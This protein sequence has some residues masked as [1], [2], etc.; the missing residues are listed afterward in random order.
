MCPPSDVKFLR[1]RVHRD[2]SKSQGAFVAIV[3][4]FPTFVI[5]SVH[6]AEKTNWRLFNKQCKAER[7]HPAHRNSVCKN[8]LH[9]GH[10]TSVCM[11]NSKIT[12]CAYCGG[13]H[14]YADHKCS[15]PG[16]TETAP[17][18]HTVLKCGLCN[19]S[20]DHHTFDKY[21][22]IWKARNPPPTPTPAER[23]TGTAHTTM[24]TSE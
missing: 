20:G 16:C 24:E 21:C 17:C 11:H 12:N 23:P 9:F 13:P 3:A 19:T 10:P 1:N 4:T 14:F 5:T 22:P 15:A 8:C 6:P 18:H 2:T 7:M